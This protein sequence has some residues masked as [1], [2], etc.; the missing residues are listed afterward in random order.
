MPHYE[1]NDTFKKTKLINNDILQLMRDRDS[2]YARARSL[3]KADD[4]NIAKCLHNRVQMAIKAHKSNIIKEDLE[5]YKNNPR[6]LWEKIYEILPKNEEA[7]IN[8][9]MDSDNNIKLGKKQLPNYINR[10]F[11]EIGPTLAKNHLQNNPV[12]N[13]ILHERM[14]EVKGYHMPERYKSL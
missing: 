8:S 10:Y 13:K 1:I 7:Q 5:R 11:S 6:N 3:N 14:N 12:Y 9:L 4:W 2:Y